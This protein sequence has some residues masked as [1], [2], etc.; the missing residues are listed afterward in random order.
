MEL[1][2]FGVVGTLLQF[3]QFGLELFSQ[4][5]E[6]YDS[7]ADT[8]AESVDTRTIAHLWMDRIETARRTVA[9]RPDVDFEQLC[10]SCRKVALDLSKIICRLEVHG[11]H[12]KWASFKAAVQRVMKK[13]DVEVL[14]TRFE[15]LRNEID[16]YTANQKWE[17]IR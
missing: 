9:T 5:K 8:L 6:I 3:V 7:S 17:I 14:K 13:K 16:R 12:R 10:D 1:V 2:A 4:C 11:T 15:T